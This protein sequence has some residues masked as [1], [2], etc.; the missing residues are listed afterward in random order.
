MRTPFPPTSRTVRRRR[1]RDT[2]AACR[3][4]AAAGRAR[5]M[6]PAAADRPGPARRCRA[7]RT[8]APAPM[9]P[10]AACLLRCRCAPV[11][12]RRH[13]VAAVASASCAHPPPV[14]T[15]RR[16]ATPAPSRPWRRHCRSM[17]CAS[18]S[19]PCRPESTSPIA[20][21][22]SIATARTVSYSAAS[23]PG[24]PA[25]AIQL[26]ESFTSPRSRM[27]AAARLVIAS[28]TAMRPDAGASMSASGVR[29]P[30][31]IASPA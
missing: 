22:V 21:Q 26:A 30:M 5:R 14:R 2:R 25:G 15:P 11:R 18:T 24:C 31:A 16:S 20:T 8:P 3:R 10:I 17:S 29:S 28:P 4:R 19:S 13:R 6:P 27:P 12:C 9:R 7:A 1:C 23:S